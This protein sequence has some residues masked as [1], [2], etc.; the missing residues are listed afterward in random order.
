MA[1][2]LV[3]HA[4]NL[5][6]NLLDKGGS[7]YADERLPRKSWYSQLHF[8]LAPYPP[9]TSPIPVLEVKL[10]SRV[11]LLAIPWTVAYQ[12][13]L[14]MDFSRQEYWSGLPFPSPG[15]SS[16][17][18]DQTRVFHMAG[19][20]FTLRGTREA[21]TCMV[22]YLSNELLGYLYIIC[23]TRGNNQHIQ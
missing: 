2:N 14:S 3:F 5:N 18:G 12:A 1:P 10:L 19:R 4:R 23:Y 16:W 13:P 8:L 15:E 6:E 9:P 20:C 17:P 21:H 11:W 22:N 7:E